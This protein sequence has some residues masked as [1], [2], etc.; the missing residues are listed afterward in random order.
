M[1]PLLL[2]VLE[3][4]LAIAITVLILLATYGLSIRLT[5][6]IVRGSREKRKPFACGES[7]PL[8]KT[9]LPDSGMYT[10]V[11]KLVF[12]SLYRSLRDKVHTGVLSDWLMWM[13]IFM[14]I[15]VVVSMVVL[16]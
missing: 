13:F 1:S 5:R 10:A 8:T 4:S 2:I 3:A 11:W 12:K 7:M 16:I 6:S 14:V 15:M 9:S